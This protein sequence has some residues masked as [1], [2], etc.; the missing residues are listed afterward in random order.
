LAAPDV[1]RLDAFDDNRGLVF[2]SHFTACPGS[3]ARWR[4]RTPVKPCR[5]R[6]PSS[7]TTPA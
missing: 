6:L 5:T 1:D 3:C 7:G 2:R 4:S